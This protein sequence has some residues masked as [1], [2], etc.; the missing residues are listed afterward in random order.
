MPSGGANVESSLDGAPEL[1]AVTDALPETWSPT[2]DFAFLHSLVSSS[3]RDAQPVLHDASSLL[4]TGDGA[5]VA[6]VTRDYEERYLW[7]PS[8]GE[9]PCINGTSCESVSM[10]LADGVPGPVLKQFVPP[11]RPASP[12]G[13][14]CLLCE[15]TSIARAHFMAL[16]AQRTSPPV[17]VLQRHCNAVDA[18]GEYMS[19]SCLLP[20]G[21]AVTGL[22]SPCVL[23]TRSSYEPCRRDG[24]RGW[25]QLYPNVSTDTPTGGGGIS[26]S[27]SPTDFLARLAVR[28][29]PA[30]AIVPTAV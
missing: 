1:D 10:A 2:V 25:R 3:R 22:V 6:L 11:G 4:S 28:P 24:L 13:G 19:V 8:Y 23:H 26:A 15:R 18:P 27:E 7:E 29:P 21:G 30:A 17:G 12:G 9:S 16:T 14:P 20:V 5:H